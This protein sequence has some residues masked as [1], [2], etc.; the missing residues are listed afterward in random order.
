[1]TNES[2]PT[3]LADCTVKDIPRAKELLASIKDKS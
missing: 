2:A 3:F 1:V